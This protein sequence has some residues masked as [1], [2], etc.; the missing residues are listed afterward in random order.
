MPQ[1]VLTLEQGSL[2]EETS[3]ASVTD[4][5]KRFSYR[6]AKLISNVTICTTIGIE[7][8]GISVPSVSVLKPPEALPRA[9]LNIAPE[10]TGRH[11]IGTL[12]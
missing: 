5:S 8:S 1:I 10:I 12:E 2:S 11:G 4:F 9:F 7:T 3:T 6:G